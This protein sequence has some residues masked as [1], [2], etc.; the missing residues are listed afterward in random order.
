MLNILAVSDRRVDSLITLLQSNARYFHE[1]LDL[2]ISCG[3]LRPS[4]IE[5]IAGTL[6]KMVYY[7]EGNHHANISHENVYDKESRTFSL[8]FDIDEDR[9]SAPIPG[10][11]NLH[12]N[13]ITTDGCRLVGFAGCMWYNGG[14][15]QYR[16]GE[17]RRFTRSMSG[18]LL[19]SRVK[20][21]ILRRPVQP[22]IVVTH[23]PV[24]GIGDENESHVHRGFTSF[25]KFI[26]FNRP[27]LWLYGHVHLNH[28]SNVSIFEESD[29]T[30]VNCYGYKFISISDDGLIRV[31]FNH[32][33]LW[34]GPSSPL[35]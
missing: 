7:V 26:E 20:H 19:R 18:R 25:R 29:T 3:D 35:E 24:A 32:A 22:L 30:F 4:Y 17:M 23:S 2:V 5:L 6:N 10:G 16:E 15:N 28:Y 9:K 12:R 14:P 33:D 13:H 8:S 11:I 21:F 34:G 27:I 1:K 31:S